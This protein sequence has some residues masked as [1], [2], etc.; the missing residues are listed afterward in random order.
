MPRTVGSAR[1]L[2]VVSSVGID[3]GSEEAV[4]VASESIF[5]VGL[6]VVV[7]CESENAGSESDVASHLP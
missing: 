6:E 7:V 4:D 2:G 5:P 1:S 3:C